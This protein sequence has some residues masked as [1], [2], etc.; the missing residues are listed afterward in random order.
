[1]TI[2]NAELVSV[3][4]RL[5]TDLTQRHRLQMQLV[6]SE[7][8]QIYHLPLAQLLIIFLKIIKNVRHLKK[9]F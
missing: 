8:Y 1:M 5:I 9:Q 2:S 7:K 4:Y 3:R 6:F